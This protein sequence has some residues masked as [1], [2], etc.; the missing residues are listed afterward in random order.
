MTDQLKP[1]QKH[2]TPT[3]GF[4]DRVFYET[5]LR[6]N[7]NS[8]MAQDWCV[9]YGVLS[10]QEAEKLYKLVLKRKNKVPSA[11][12]SKTKSGGNSKVVKNKKRK[13]VKEEADD[14]GMDVGGSEGIG[15]VTL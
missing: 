5:L 6:Q 7:P 13:V 8:E 1:G 3:K 15:G 2:P 12:A 11:S 14:V 9:A 4:G 10:I